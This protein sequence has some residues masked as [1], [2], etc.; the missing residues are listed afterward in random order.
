VAFFRRPPSR[1][2]ARWLG[3]NQADGD[4]VWR[5]AMGIAGLVTLPIPPRKPS[6]AELRGA[7]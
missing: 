3:P 1:L 2:L 7:W 6:S 5:P 4:P